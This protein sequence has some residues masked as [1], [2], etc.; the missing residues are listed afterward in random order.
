[1]QPGRWA[2]SGVLI[3]NPLAGA[4]RVDLVDAG[5]LA[6]SCAELVGDLTVIGTRYRGH[7]EEIAVK[8]VA[9][10]ADLVVVAGG[11]GTTREVASG[12]VRAG[13]ERSGALLP[14]LFCVPVGTANSFYREIWS[15][16]PW[17]QTLAEALS[18]P[19]RRVRHIDVAH[20]QESDTYAL[21]GTGTGVVAEVLAAAN[22]LT[23]LAGRDRYRQAVA[24]V[25]AAHRPYPARITV[26]GEVV[27]DGT[28]QLTNIGGGRYR[29]G[30]FKLMPRSVLDD[31]LLD[32]CAFDGTCDLIELLNLTRE[33][34][35]VERPGVIYTRGRHFVVERTDGAPLSL[36]YDGEMATGERSRCTVGL[37]AGVLPFLAPP[38]RA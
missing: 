19:A 21:L 14:A 3:T 20:I 2:D 22:R 24:R 28:V 9:D 27:H 26:D 7:A 33:G 18:G 25:V 13:V 35:H 23:E 4:G 29:A 8:A 5:T 30:Q 15:D 32:L 10:G 38:H 31:G 37:R 1:M 16:R 17:R 6:R 34:Q 12:L 11:D 36:E